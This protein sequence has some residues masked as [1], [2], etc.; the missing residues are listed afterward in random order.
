MKVSNSYAMQC[1]GTLFSKSVEMPL[2]L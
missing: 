2:N 1:T